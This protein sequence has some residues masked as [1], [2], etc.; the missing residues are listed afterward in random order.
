MADVIRKGIEECVRNERIH[1]E[2][3][4][5]LVHNEHERWALMMEE[6]EESCE[7][8]VNIKDLMAKMWARIK[9]NDHVSAAQTCINIRDWAIDMA[10]EACQLA[11][12]C[13]KEYMKPGYV[14]D[15]EG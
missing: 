4:F 5:G 14:V 6:F 9:I 3:K 13:D 10:I 2:E 1:A 12:M 15:D 8:A 11:A 7:C